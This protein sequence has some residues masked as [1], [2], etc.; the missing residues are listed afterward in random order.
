M[1]SAGT[2]VPKS[3]IKRIG[4]IVPE[5][6]KTATGTE[7]VRDSGERFA[8]GKT[9]EGIKYVRLE[10]NAF[11]NSDGSD[12]TP[13]EAYNSLVG[14]QIALEDGDVITFIKNLPGRSVYKELFKKFPGYEP[15]IDVKAVSES[16]NKNI[17]EVIEASEIQTRNEPQKHPHIGIVDFDSRSVYLTDGTNVYR[18][19]L[20]IANLTDGTKIAYVKRYIENASTEIKKKIKKAETAG[21]THLNQPSKSSIPQKSQNSNS[22]GENI[23]KYVAPVSETEIRAYSGEIQIK[24]IERGDCFYDITKIKDI[25]DSAAG[26][27]LI[28]A[29]GS[30]YDISKYS[31]SQ[32]SQNSN[33]SVENILEK[34]DFGERFATLN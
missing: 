8:V 9:K 26:Q 25:T 33:T 17:V 19:E 1:Q 7:N 13:M 28:K 20:N 3:V 32:T 16:I 24:L 4:K 23:S 2:Q 31:I 34:V 18:L 15:G 11:K 5:N 12:M 21:Q 29:A 27:A 30:V 22:S 6:E 14:K 10:D